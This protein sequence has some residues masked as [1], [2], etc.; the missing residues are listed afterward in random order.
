MANKSSFFYSAKRLDQIKLKK[1][2]KRVQFSD[3]CTVHEIMR[4]QFVDVYYCGTNRKSSKFERKT[5]LSRLPWTL[6]LFQLMHTK[7]TGFSLI[8]RLFRRNFWSNF[9]F[10]WFFSL[11][12][13]WSIW[14]SISALSSASKRAE[15]RKFPSIYI[16]WIRAHFAQ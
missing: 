5:I 12:S 9:F 16:I 1:T 13:S 14:M 7:T 11:Q 3:P 2:E 4:S 8:C 10:F 6:Q 15:M